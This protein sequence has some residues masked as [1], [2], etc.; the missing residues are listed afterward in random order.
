VIFPEVNACFPWY[1]AQRYLYGALTTECVA[2]MNL[3]SMI[4]K[5]VSVSKLL[6]D[7]SFA[8]A[9]RRVLTSLTSALTTS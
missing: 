3:N 2:T 1:G 5:C 9:Q 6:E 8:Q 4:Y 7:L